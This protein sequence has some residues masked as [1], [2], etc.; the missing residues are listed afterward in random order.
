MCCI[1]ASV[2]KVSPASSNGL[3]PV[4][5]QAINL[6]NADSLWIGPLRT[7]LSEIWIEIQIFC[8]IKCHLRNSVILSSGR[9]VKE[10]EH[11]IT[12]SLCTVYTAELHM[13]IHKEYYCGSHKLKPQSQPVFIPPKPYRGSKLQWRP[14][15]RGSVSNHQPHDCLLNRLFSCRSKKTSKLRVTSL[16]PGT[17]EFPTQRASNTE[18]VDGV[19]MK[20]CNHRLCLSERCFDISQHYAMCWLD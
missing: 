6:N 1:Y 3:S 15:G 11:V 2:N 20:H 18:N 10:N 5:H 17:G 16:S 7:I 8:F 19:I 13:H 14:N 4:R 12:Q 9:W